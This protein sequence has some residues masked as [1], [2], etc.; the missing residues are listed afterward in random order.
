MVTVIPI[1]LYH[2]IGRPPVGARVPGQYVSPPLF[3]R[4][5][6][7]LRGRGYHSVSLSRLTQ[8]LSA[9]PPKPV[10]ITFDDGYRC[11]HE[12][13]LPALEEYGF[14]ATVFL[15]AGGLGGVNYWETAVGDAEEPMLGPTE[16]A[17]MGAAGLEFG[18][19]TLNHPHL[20]SLPPAAAA[21]EIAD[22]KAILEDHLGEP[23]RSFAYPYGDWNQAVRNLVAA[24][25]HEF[26]CTTLRR[27]AR[28]SDD[29]LALPRLNIRRYNLL[30]RFS[31]KLWRASRAKP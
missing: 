19:H 7:Y 12:H 30:P 8:P 21:R 31:Y 22:A 24:A 25:G 16:I 5:L 9:L 6:A 20:T 28:R 2:K 10:V 3:R 17:E 4:H 29:P 26:A 18:S 14:T 11:L 23:C 27:A 15:V 1:L 13:A